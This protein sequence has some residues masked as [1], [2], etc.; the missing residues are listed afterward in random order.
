MILDP[1]KLTLK[2][3]HRSVTKKEKTYGLFQFKPRGGL[4]CWKIGKKLIR[5]VV[6]SQK[7]DKI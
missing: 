2:I 7:R 5:A 3:N 6:R 4:A 1:I